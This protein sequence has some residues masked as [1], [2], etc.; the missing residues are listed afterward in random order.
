LTQAAK[1][2]GI[3]DET[4]IDGSP[5]LPHPGIASRLRLRWSWQRGQHW[6]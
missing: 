5:I 4:H 6:S 1:A 3:A 2:P